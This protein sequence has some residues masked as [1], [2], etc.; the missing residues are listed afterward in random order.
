MSKPLLLYADRLF[1]TDP[2]VRAITRRL[3][4]SVANLPILSPHGHTDPEWFATDASFGNATD[5]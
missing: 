5:C 4:D 3:Y 2:N 1:P